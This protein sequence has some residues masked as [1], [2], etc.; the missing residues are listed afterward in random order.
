MLGRSCSLDC[1]P[2]PSLNLL[3]CVKPMPQ[4]IPSSRRQLGHNLNLVKWDELTRRAADTGVRQRIDAIFRMHG[5]VKSLNKETILDL[6]PHTARGSASYSTFI[7]SASLRM[8]SKS[9]DE[10]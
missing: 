2:P 10:R 3:K 9:A 6:P 7:S 4:Q 1:N 5:L 8:S